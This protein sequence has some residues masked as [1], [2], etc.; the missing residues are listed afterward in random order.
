MRN[1]RSIHNSGYETIL[2]YRNGGKMKKLG[3]IGGTGPESTLVY[4]R[5]LNRLINEKNR[6]QRFSG[7]CLRKCEFI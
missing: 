5:E 4:Y 2:K 3:L 7:T 1:G 6:G